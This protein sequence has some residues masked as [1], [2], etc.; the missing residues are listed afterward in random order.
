[1]WKLIKNF[2]EPIKQIKVID[3]EVK[4]N[5]DFINPKP[6]SNLGYI[7]KNSKLINILVKEIKKRNVNFLFDSS[8][9]DLSY[10]NSKILVS[11]MK[12]K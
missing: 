4:A 11:Q 12:K 2:A 5:I 6:K 7:V 3:K 8:L 10:Q 1:M 9:N